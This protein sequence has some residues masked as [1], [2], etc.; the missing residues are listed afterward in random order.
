MVPTG[1]PE[2]I[3]PDN[4]AKHNADRTLLKGPAGNIVVRDVSSGAWA[5]GRGTPVSPSP[6]ATSTSISSPF[7][8]SRDQDLLRERILDV[9]L[10]GALER[11]RTEVLVVPV[12]PPGTPSP[13]R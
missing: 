12:R 6:A 11:P 4:I 10:N 3:Q 1:S 2:L 5:T 7:E 9:A 13:R 8:N